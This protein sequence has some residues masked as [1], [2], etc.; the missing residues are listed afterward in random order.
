MATVFCRDSRVEFQI[1]FGNVHTTRYRPNTPATRVRIYVVDHSV[2]GQIAVGQ[3]PS[4]VWVD[5]NWVNQLIMF[6]IASRVVIIFLI[7]YCFSLFRRRSEL[8]VSRRRSHRLLAIAVVIIIIYFFFL[9]FG[10]LVIVWF[11][12]DIVVGLYGQFRTPT[13]VRFKHYSLNS[14]KNCF[15]HPVLFTRLFTWAHLQSV[16][17]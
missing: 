11:L 13:C 7:I 8:F 2:S 15:F 12:G 5:Y 1:S 9:S 4:H 14:E 10:L 6:N 16:F 3:W 17:I